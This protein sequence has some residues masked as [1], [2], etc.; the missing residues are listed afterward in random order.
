MGGGGLGFRD[1]EC[2]NQA[3]LAKQAWRLIQEPKCLFAKFFKSRYFE[4]GQFLESSV[5]ARP[6][7]AWRSILHGRDLLTKSLVKKVGNGKSLR[8][9]MDPWI[10]EEGWRASYRKQTFFNHDLRVKDLIHRPTRGWNLDYLNEL[11]FPNDVRLILKQKP[12]IRTNDFWCWD[13]NKSGDYTVKSGYWLACR[14]NKPELLQEASQ[15]PSINGLKEQIWSIHTVPKIKAF[16]WRASSN[17]LP[18]TDLLAKRGVILDSRCQVCG[19][20]G[21]YINHVLF[22]CSIARQVWALSNFPSPPEG[23]DAFSLFSN[24]HYLYKSRL[25][26]RI[27]MELRRIFPWVLWRLWKNRNLFF[28][29]ESSSRPLKLLKKIRE[30]V[31]F[32]CLAQ[33][34]KDEVEEAKTREDTVQSSKWKPPEINW[35]KCNIGVFWD[36]KKRVGGCAWVLRNNQGVS[37]LHS[38]RGFSNIISKDQLNLQ[39]LLWAME[40]MH[41]HNVSKVNFSTDIV[42]L[43]KVMQRPKAW[44]SFY[45]HYTEMA[46]LLKKIREWRLTFEHPSAN[47][48]AFL[49]AQSATREFLTQSFIAVGYP[50]WLQELFETE[51]N[52]SSA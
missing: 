3:L 27:P 6:S 29:K 43:V 41:S 42:D 47:R 35:L 52:L 14:L 9:W 23:F 33:T 24:L 25:D 45:Y 46:R 40:S 18:V 38:R 51:K 28:M 12:V 32:W 5:G 19:L 10:Y 31:E 17:A 39:A 48:G 50:F 20:E 16:L 8:V 2:F 1:I 36:K 26:C 15:Q 30:D 4:N 21:E 13:H 7:Y 44:P 49:V 22:T 34:V 11:C 37:L